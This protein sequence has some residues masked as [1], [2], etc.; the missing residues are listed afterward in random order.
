LTWSGSSTLDR[1]SP[2]AHSRLKPAL[3][4][5]DDDYDDA[6][7]EDFGDEFDE[8]EEGAQAGEDDEFGD[9][10]DGFEGPRVV[11]EVSE[12]L[13]QLYTEPEPTLVSRLCS[14]SSQSIPAC[15]DYSRPSMFICL[16]RGSLF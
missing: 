13:P 9:F 7:S 4:H 10:D 8:F 3:T 14:I 16:F 1:S 6:R 2:R 12:S 5:D 15:Y 11:E